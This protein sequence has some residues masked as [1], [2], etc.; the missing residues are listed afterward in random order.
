MLS[1]ERILHLCRVSQMVYQVSTV[2]RGLA[3]AYATLKQRLFTI[4]AKS[5]TRS[6]CSAMVALSAW[7]SALIWQRLTSGTCIM[8]LDDHIS[9]AASYRLASAAPTTSGPD[10]QP[11]QRTWTTPTPSSAPFLPTLS[12]ARPAPAPCSVFEYA[13]TMST[14]PDCCDKLSCSA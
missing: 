4:G 14:T 6:A 8:L 1:L 11:G 12:P 2:K 7:F 13:P 10:V 3:S 9:T 5:F